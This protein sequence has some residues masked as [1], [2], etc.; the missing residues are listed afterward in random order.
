MVKIGKANILI[1]LLNQKEKDLDLREA[2]E[3]GA[4]YT[5]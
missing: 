5:G 4:L 1:V 3:K 2:F